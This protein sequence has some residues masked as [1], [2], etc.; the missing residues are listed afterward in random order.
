MISCLDWNSSITYNLTGK[1]IKY[2]V[3]PENCYHWGY[4]WLKPLYIKLKLVN[5]YVWMD[6][7]THTNVNLAMTDMEKKNLTLKWPFPKHYNIEYKTAKCIYV[8][9]L[10]P[11][12]SLYSTFQPQSCHIIFLMAIGWYYLLCTLWN[13]PQTDMV[14]F[15]NSLEATC[16]G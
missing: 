8:V 14:G 10:L 1:C 12:K 16:W 13:S 3:T 9:A 11:L 6:S 4:H 5:K 7:G 15:M 2:D